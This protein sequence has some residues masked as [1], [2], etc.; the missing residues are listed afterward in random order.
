MKFATTVALLI[1]CVAFSPLPGDAEWCT[2]ATTLS[3]LAERFPDNRGPDIVVRV[4]RGEPIQD[5]IERAT[6][7]NGDGFVIVAAVN[8]GIGSPYGT[9][10]Q[11][12]VVDRVFPRPF[13]LFGCSLSLR[14]PAPAD[15]KP[16]AHITRAAAPKCS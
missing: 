2:K 6:D 15:N 8:S 9:T 11:R 14:D 4:D 5:A 7:L 3:G 16:T 10:A 12:V 1:L 13:G